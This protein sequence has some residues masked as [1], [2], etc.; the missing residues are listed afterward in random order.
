LVTLAANAIKA[1]KELD[2]HFHPKMDEDRAYQLGL[3]TT[4]SEAEAYKYVLALTH[5]KADK[6]GTRS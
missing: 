1:K 6:H 3:I 2:K 4:G 5:G